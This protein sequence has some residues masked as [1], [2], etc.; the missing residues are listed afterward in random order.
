MSHLVVVGLTLLVSIRSATTRIEHSLSDLFML[1]SYGVEQIIS[2]HRFFL[3]MI[4]CH[5]NA[6]STVTAS[7]L[8]RTENGLKCS[9]EAKSCAK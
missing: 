5:N 8:K 9:K 1:R 7:F 4:D 3:M 6:L 2:R